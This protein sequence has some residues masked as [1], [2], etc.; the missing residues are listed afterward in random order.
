ML[1]I[2]SQRPVEL[3]DTVISQCSN[4]FIFKMTHPLDIDYIEKMLPNI[5]SD[6]IEKQKSLQ[7]GNCVAFGSAFKIPMIIKLEMPSPAPNSS[8][9]NVNARWK[10]QA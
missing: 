4:F 5:S 1:N 3:S 10:Y 2:I 9:C 7:P 8:S 6:I